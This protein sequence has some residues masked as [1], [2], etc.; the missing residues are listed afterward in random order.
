MEKKPN[1]HIKMHDGSWGVILY[2]REDGDVV[3]YYCG[4]FE[5]ACR[6]AKKH[7]PPRLPKVN[8]LQLG[9]P[10]IEGEIVSE[11]IRSE[12]P[13]Q[14][15]LEDRPQAKR[16]RSLFRRRVGQEA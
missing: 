15:V 14:R 13:R 1:P 9:P 2:H 10:I 7:A 5:E 16:Q 6:L 12:A 11:A 4:G 8:H 3:F